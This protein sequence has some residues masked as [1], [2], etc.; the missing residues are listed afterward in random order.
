M[1]R[2]LK[3]RLGRLKESGGLGVSDQSAA[4]GRLDHPG[5]PGGQVPGFLADW[6]QVSPLVFSRSL[7]FP[8]PLPETIDGSPLLARMGRSGDL[9]SGGQP[10]KR[11]PLDST[12]LRF[13]DL[14]TTG[15]SGGAG[16]VAFLATIGRVVRK[17]GQSTFVLHQ[18]FLR[19]YPGEAQFID[20]VLA[21]LGPDPRLVSY[22]GRAYDLPLLRSRCVMSRIQPPSPSLHIDLLYTARRLWRSRFGGASL[23]LLEKEVLGRERIG[24]VAGAAIP[25]IWFSFLERGEHE[26][27]GAVVSHNADDVVSL[28]ALLARAALCFDG[29]A[30]GSAAVDIDLFSLGRVFLAIGRASEA[31][32]ALEAAANRGSGDAALLLARIWRR[33]GR[34]AAA[35]AILALAGDNFEAAMESARLA[36]KS[37]DDLAVALASTENAARF[38]SNDDQRSRARTRLRRLGIKAAAVS[39][40]RPGCRHS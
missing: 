13:L 22:N 4:Q 21:S 7:S 37:E 40:A 24:D 26:S 33:A 6:E 12:S 18:V 27:M 17:E 39:R 34:K 8:D 32:F 36:E 23:S 38:A 11:L 15:L 25:G 2:S 5:E 28:A 31:E 30:R 29:G 3:A 1:G 19:D 14:E 16:T 20:R 10:A 9:H 35:R